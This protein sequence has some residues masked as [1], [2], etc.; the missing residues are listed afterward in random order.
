MHIPTVI[1][2]TM[3]WQILLD[4]GASKYAK[5]K[6]GSNPYD[7]ACFFVDE[8]ASADERSAVEFILNPDGVRH[9][10]DSEY[11]PLWRVALIIGSI[12]LVVLIAVLLAVTACCVVYGPSLST[13]TTNPFSPKLS[14]I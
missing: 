1:V 8:E 13:D 11:R 5:D 14:N 7:V 4:Y 2:M 6:T 10:H 9:D 12:G 3:P